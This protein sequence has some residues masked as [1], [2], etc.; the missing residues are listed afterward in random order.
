MI[1]LFNHEFDNR[2][3]WTTRKTLQVRARARWPVL[4]SY[5][6]M[7]STVLL[8][9]PINDEIRTGDSQ[10]DLRILLSL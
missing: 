4:S 9:C 8:H 3:N 5:S 6:G 10:S 2:P 1:N 7:T